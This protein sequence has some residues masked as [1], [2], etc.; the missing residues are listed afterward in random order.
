MQTAWDRWA[1]TQRLGDTLEDRYPG[2]D[3]KR[4]KEGEVAGWR[5]ALEEQAAAAG[6]DWQPFQKAE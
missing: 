6:D 2:F 1:A 4:I 5:S 3:V